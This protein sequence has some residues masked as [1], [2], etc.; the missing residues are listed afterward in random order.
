[1][2]GLSPSDSLSGGGGNNV[3]GRGTN[4]ERFRAQA[5]LINPVHRSPIRTFS[6]NNSVLSWGINEL[7]A[8]RFSPFQYHRNLNGFVK[9]FMGVFR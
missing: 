8:T 1:M 4:I 3:D 7:L 5:V 9:T 6:R 2:H